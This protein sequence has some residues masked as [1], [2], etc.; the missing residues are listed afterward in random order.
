MVL[1][2]RILLYIFRGEK[3]EKTKKNNILFTVIMSVFLII[4]CF[5][6]T[7]VTFQNDT[8][9]TI[10]IGEDISEQGIDMMDHFSWH[11][12]L[13]Y[14][15]PHWLFDLMTYKFYS[16][17]GLAGVYLM[18]CIFASILGLSIY[19]CNYNLSKNNVTSFLISLLTMF[20]M[21]NFIT[22]RAQIVTFSLFILTI[23]FIEKFLK[24]KK[25]FYGILLFIISVLIVNIHVAVWPFFFIL[26]LPPI[27]A[28][29][30]TFIGDKIAEN[31][32]DIKAYEKDIKKLKKTNPNSE[33][34][35]EYEQKIEILEQERID[36]INQRQNKL[37][38]SYKIVQKRNPNVKWLA[39]I[40]LVCT[41]AGI[42]TPLG[43]STSYT[44]LLKTLIGDS[45]Q[46][47]SEHQPTV[48]LNSPPMLLFII[49]FF[50]TLLFTKV[51]IKL[52][53]LFL[54]GGLALLS[55]S[56]YRQVSMLILLDSFALV[57]ILN[58]L[59]IFKD[60]NS[61]KII[62][63][64]SSHPIVYLYIFLFVIG[65]ASTPITNNC[66][67]RFVEEE[68]YPIEATKYITNNLDV[69]NMNLFNDYDFGS[70]LLFNN[71]PVFIDS[72]CDL[73]LPEYNGENCTV[74]DD[75][76][77]IKSGEVHCEEIFKKYDIT[78]MIIAKDSLI[79][80]EIIGDGGNRYNE[81]YSDNYFAVFERISKI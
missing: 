23:F 34:I 78:H 44:Y 39:L 64:I 56:S 42:I 48:L 30:W 49:L 13:E 54:V 63:N 4:F 14:T 41:L 33:K 11:D 15:Y 36:R 16:A 18:T 37:K 75:F 60:N 7:P 8:F 31:K 74:F 79:Y 58:Q 43:A 55:I 62:T 46:Y 29:I 57:K 81:L 66:N 22:A 80:T 59:S 21:I 26:F 76:M 69:N 35:K 2:D 27:G 32:S 72:R 40:M 25:F 9:Y 70:Y 24:T 61:N 77:S 10:A 20:L 45:T 3:M 1:N 73:Y 53:D 65:I 68:M 6:I 67:S 28:E 52:S 50:G 12:N 71:I 17:L 47:I 38:N 51:K 19:Y 5:A